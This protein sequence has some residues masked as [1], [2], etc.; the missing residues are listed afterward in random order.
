MSL[1]RQLLVYL[2]IAAPAAW[3]I[4]LLISIQKTEH[5]VN[6][7]FDTQ[8]IHL[9]REV[10]GSVMTLGS[11]RAIPIHQ[12]PASHDAATLGD[13][14]V[15][16]IAIAAW[17]GQGQQIL[18]DLASQLLP[19]QVNTS[20]FV[21]VSIQ[22]EAWRVYY[23]QSA[24]ADLVIAAGQKSH[25]RQELV[26]NLVASQIL[27][28]LLVLPFL[29]F[30]MS[31]AVRFALKPMRD[32]V[33]DL[34]ARSADDFTR[35]QA[36]DQP[37]E[38]QPLLKAMNQLFERIQGLLQ[39][40]R[41]FVA[42]AAHELRTPL[43]VLRAQWD[44]FKKSHNSEHPAVTEAQLDMG[45]ERIERLVAQ[46]LQMSQ[47]DAT[48]TLPNPQAIKWRDVLEHAVMDVLLLADNNHVEIEAHWPDDNTPVLPVLGI[49]VLMTALIRN[50]LDN[51]IRYSPPDSTVHIQFTTSSITVCNTVTEDA[52]TRTTRWGERFYR[53]AGSHSS[54]S[55]LGS[56]IVKRI[57]QLHGLSAVATAPDH[58]QVCITLT[59]L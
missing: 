2:L 36:H 25:E 14:E 3:F 54:G 40:E 37:S 57:A 33:N 58:Q 26:W 22:D 45:F 30:G 51:A 11:S 15:D 50:L 44:A 17:N 53:P 6:E 46:M 41:R 31:L 48:E 35:L 42:D 56:S 47:L 32:L 39:R 38:L 20:G 43:A 10:Q 49:N 5:E 18:G 12:A 7:L 59:R 1:H 8:M 16:D 29:L 28:W 52:Q 24:N 27:P 23:L 34:T 55:G 9:A 21:N 13:A 4:A 19:F